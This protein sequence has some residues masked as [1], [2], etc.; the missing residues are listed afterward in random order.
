MIDN[1]KL[2]DFGVWAH[3]YYK[4]P[5]QVFKSSVDGMVLERLWNEYW[6]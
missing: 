2:A 6:M 1:E 4:I 5:V 3:K